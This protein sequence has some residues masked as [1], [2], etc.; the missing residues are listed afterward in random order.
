MKYRGTLFWVMLVLALI[1][2]Y[3]QPVLST[4]KSTATTMPT[5]IHTTK[6]T[7][8]TLPSQGIAAF[9]G[10]DI[11][12]FTQ[13][14]GQP[15]D[16]LA[17]GFD[18]D[19]YS[20]HPAQN[21]GYIEVSVA[22]HKIQ[23]IKLVESQQAD[24]A[25]FAFGMEMSDLTRLVTISPN[26]DF[27]YQDKKVTLELGEEDMNYR[28]LIALDDGHF[29]MLFLD[30]TNGTLDSLMYLTKEML[31]KLAPYTLTGKDLPVFTVEEDADWEKINSTKQQ[32]A[33]YVFSLMTYHHDLSAYQ[34][35][36]ALDTAATKALTEFIANPTDYLTTQRTLDLGN[37]LKPENHD[38]FLLTED[39]WSSL[40]NG[41]VKKRQGYFERPVY[42]PTFTLLTWYSSAYLNVYGQP[43][44]QSLSIAFSK[45]N[46]LVLIQE[47]ESISE[48]SDKK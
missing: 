22:K 48:E 46:M 6:T 15:T 41:A 40:N 35:D 17:T 20:Y 34:E 44:K 38:R 5:A 24:I 25:P 16:I 47:M 23:A 30:Q 43:T 27:T 21:H 11:E 1:I 29:V 12:T 8:E 9:V 39:E 28:P 13:A 26:F 10:E 42:D 36:P 7:Y 33:R 32:A 37:A 3:A 19:I 4:S 31:L 18:Y 45:A 2:V 14:Y